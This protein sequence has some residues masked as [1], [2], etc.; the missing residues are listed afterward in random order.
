MN[1]E[2]ASASVTKDAEQP[3]ADHSVLIEKVP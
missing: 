2:N 1:T 3:V